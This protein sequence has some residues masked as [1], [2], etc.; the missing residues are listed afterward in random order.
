MPGP[1][2]CCTTSA[3]R[4]LNL[5]SSVGELSLLPALPA[6]AARHLLAEEGEVDLQP[7]LLTLALALAIA[8]TLASLALRGYLAFRVPSSLR[9]A[10]I[11]ILLAAGAIFALPT[12]Q[13]AAQSLS[14]PCV[15]T[16]MQ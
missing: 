14:D 13:G 8:D 7:W 12:G 16:T 11:L 10:A 4:A 1:E 2:N 6:G 9:R 5:A 3:R 15:D